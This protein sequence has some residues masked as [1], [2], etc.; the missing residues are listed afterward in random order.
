MNT[1]RYLRAYMAGIVVPTIAVPLW[2]R[3]I[4]HCSLRIP[5]LDP[6][7]ACCD[8]PDGVSAHILRTVE[9]A[10]RATKHRTLSSPWIAWRFASSGFYPSWYD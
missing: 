9:H 7:R 2:T 10:L 5:D 8:F 1:H 3:C 6:N 4:L